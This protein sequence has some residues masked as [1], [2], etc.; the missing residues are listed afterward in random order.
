M[1]TFRSFVDRVPNTRYR[2]GY[3]QQCLQYR[4]L[5]GGTSRELATPPCFQVDYQ[6]D[7][8]QDIAATWPASICDV[9]ARADWG[10]RHRFGLDAMTD[11][12]LAALHRIH[13]ASAVPG[14]CVV[15]GPRK[16]NDENV[17]VTAA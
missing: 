15:P 5:S 9:R 7:F 6:P 10:W 8:R 14:G 17:A 16:G 12:M 13:Y 1:R 3:M 4:A 11:D 2:E